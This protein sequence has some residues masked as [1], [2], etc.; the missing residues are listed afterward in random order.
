VGRRPDDPP[1]PDVL[2]VDETV[3]VGDR[4]LSVVRPRAG[5]ARLGDE[6]F[7]D[8]LVLPYWAEM[9]PSG[10]ALANAVAGRRLCGVSVL[11]LGCGALA[12]PSIAASLAGGSVRAT[13]WSGDSLAFAARNARRNRAAVDTALCS[14]TKPEAIVSGAPWGLVLAADVLY[15]ERN[16]E[17]LLELLPRLLG[18]SGEAWIADPGRA[19]A[20]AF[21]DGV[22]THFTIE[23]R[24]VDA[25]G[26]LLHRLRPRGGGAGR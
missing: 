3:R 9:W 4:I 8:E 1:L 12:L 18:D 22:T 17:L 15:D 19:A 6:A 10:V 21:V 23:T 7:D 26:V 25:G 5:E 11:E 24:P 2:T 13:D 14:W 20:R 16:T